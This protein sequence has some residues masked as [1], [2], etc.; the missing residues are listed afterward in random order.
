MLVYQSS[1]PTQ[2]ISFRKYSFP[3]NSIIENRQANSFYLAFSSIFYPWG[4]FQIQNKQTACVDKNDLVPIF[5]TLVRRPILKKLSALIIVKLCY[6]CVKQTKFFYKNLN[7][8]RNAMQHYIANS[9]FYA[10]VKWFMILSCWWKLKRHC[11]TEIAKFGLAY[12]HVISPNGTKY[13][14]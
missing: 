13:T 6:I 5:Q 14:T 11:S 4:C 8:N 12:F 10:V 7:Q 9:Y 3:H 2:A 1:A